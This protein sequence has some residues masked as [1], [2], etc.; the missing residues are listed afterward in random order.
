M[1]ETDETRTA[2]QILEERIAFYTA[3]NNAQSSV[4]EPK[5]AGGKLDAALQ[6]ASNLAIHGGFSKAV[7]L[8]DPSSKPTAPPTSPP[9]L[10]TTDAR[11]QAAKK[12]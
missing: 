3:W 12:K 1:A 10:T 2:S 11:A 8:S 7:T 5:N 4:P 6:K 9:S